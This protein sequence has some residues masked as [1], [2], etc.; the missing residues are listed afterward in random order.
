MRDPFDSHLAKRVSVSDGRG[1]QILRAFIEARSVTEPETPLPSPAGVADPRRWLLIMENAE[2][3]GP[4]E[5]RDE[6]Y[7]YALTRWENVGGHIEG[8]LRRKGD[9]SDA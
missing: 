1:I 7:V 8:V 3:I 4:V 6:R 2:L 9:V 5:I